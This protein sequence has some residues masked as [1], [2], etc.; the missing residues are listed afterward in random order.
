[1][2]ITSIFILTATFFFLNLFVIPAYAQKDSTLVK[3]VT[4]D[5][6]EFVGKIISQDDEKIIL[7]T[8]FFGELTIK[9]D[10]IIKITEIDPAKII[11]GELWD[12]NP[13]ATRYLWTPNGYGL[14]SGEGYYQNIWVLYN[15]V[16]VGLS[17]YFSFSFGI[18]PLFLFG[19][20]LEANPLWIV[21]KVSIPLEKDKVNFSGGAFMGVI[22]GQSD[23]GFGIV[24]STLTFGDKNQNLNLGLGWGYAGGDW[25]DYPII[26]LSGMLRVTPRGYLLSENYFLNFGDDFNMTIISFGFRHMVKKVG[27]DF[28]LYIPLSSQMDEFFGF[29]VLGITIPFNK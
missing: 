28:G 22:L 24:F 17:D 14:K 2:K 7:K 29:P 16:S 15:Q 21:P 10:V 27:L 12:D 11:G 1:M 19:L 8:D 4:K 3:I 25:A 13:Q 5:Q 26:N 23:S 18:I 20:G 9:K 6:N